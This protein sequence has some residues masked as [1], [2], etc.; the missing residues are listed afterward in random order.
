MNVVF[1]RSGSPII[2]LVD[3]IWRPA[4]DTGCRDHL[5]I[6]VSSLDRIVELGEASIVA[7]GSVK[8][9][10]VS[11]FDILERERR[12]MTFPGALRAPNRGR[13]PGN[14][15]IFFQALLHVW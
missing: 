14:I 2:V 9:I 12:W 10:F 5:K 6:R 4:G 15:S 13:P 1:E 11:D 8:E 3:Y 7:P